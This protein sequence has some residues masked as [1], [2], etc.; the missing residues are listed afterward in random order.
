MTKC[1]LLKIDYSLDHYAINHGIG[2]GVYFNAKGKTIILYKVMVDNRSYLTP[3]YIYIYIYT[4]EIVLALNNDNIWRATKYLKSG[5]NT[6][7]RKI[8]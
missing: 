8:L 7:F 4:R 6:V 3:L 5:D 2:S 1:A